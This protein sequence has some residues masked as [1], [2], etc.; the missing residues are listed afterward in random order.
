[1]SPSWTRSSPGP[2]TIGMASSFKR[3][4][5]FEFPSGSRGRRTR[6][7]PT[8][9]LGCYTSVSWVIIVEDMH[10]SF[11]RHQRRVGTQ[12]GQLCCGRWV[13]FP[14]LVCLDCSLHRVG[15]D[16][17][18]TFAMQRNSSS[19]LVVQTSNRCQMRSVYLISMRLLKHSETPTCPCSDPTPTVLG[20]R[21]THD[22][23]KVIPHMISL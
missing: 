15:G 12:T 16:C 8:H 23:S 20:P 7:L 14:W 2:A 11:S 13:Q 9:Q 17:K 21:Y 1:M 10:M 18:Q 5:L 22:S 3:T 19:L 6:L 4:C